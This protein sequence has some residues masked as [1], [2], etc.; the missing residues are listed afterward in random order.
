MKGPEI[1]SEFSQNLHTLLEEMQEGNP[2]ERPDIEVKTDF[3]P[4]NQEMLS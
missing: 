2:K 1:L 3:L 4:G